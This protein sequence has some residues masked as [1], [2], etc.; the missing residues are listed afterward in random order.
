MRPRASRLGPGRLGLS[1]LVCAACAHAALA[2]AA[3]AAAPESAVEACAFLA[4]DPKPTP[5]QTP[6]QRPPQEQRVPESKLPSEGKSPDALRPPQEEELQDLAALLKSLSKAETSGPAIAALGEGRP[7]SVE[8]FGV[9]VAD[10]RSI[11]VQQHAREL[12]VRLERSGKVDASTRAWIDANVGVM[13]GCAPG[14]F[15]NRGGPTVFQPVA[16]IVVKLRGEL[17]PYLFQ[18]QAAPAAPVAPATPDTPRPTT[19][20]QAR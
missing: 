18:A 4:D 9:L 16:A 10:A 19:K 8:R 7:F 20:Q 6:A 5:A 12:R 11:L 17:E 1:A 2:T 13:E 14:R 15:E 3:P